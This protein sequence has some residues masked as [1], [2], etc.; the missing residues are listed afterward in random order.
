MK[1]IVFLFLAGI[2]VLGL[3]SCGDN[4]TKE[5]VISGGILN[6]GS[7]VPATVTSAQTVSAVQ[8][9]VTNVNS[10]I[11][12]ALTSVQSAGSGSFAMPNGKGSSRFGEYYEGDITGPDSG[13]WM[14][15][16]YLSTNVSDYY[17]YYSWKYKYRLLDSAGNPIIKSTKA[18]LWDATDVKKYQYSYYS[19]IVYS[20]STYWNEEGYTNP[21]KSDESNGDSSFEYKTAKTW[22]GGGTYNGNYNYILNYKDGAT[23]IFSS[24]IN[25]LVI[26]PTAAYGYSD[27]Y[28]RYTGGTI[29]CNYFNW[30]YHMQYNSDGTG[31]GYMRAPGYAYTVRCDASGNYTWTDDATGKPLS[32]KK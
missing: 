14:T 15:W 25:N 18:D 9:S 29:D 16:E 30:T 2:I 23:Q 19:K 6:A 20:S 22:A 32:I 4:K 24:T 7:G 10:M 5:K 28:W 31:N 27:Y 1:K 13:G 12:N 8:G 3:S 11:S 21:I 17:D 26:S